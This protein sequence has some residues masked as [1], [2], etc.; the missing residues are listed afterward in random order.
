MNTF[1]ITKLPYMGEHKE[2][3]SRIIN[4]TTKSIPFSELH[5][6]ERAQVDERLNQNTD[7]YEVLTAKVEHLSQLLGCSEADAE[8]VLFKRIGTK[9]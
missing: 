4:K 3:T 8:R 9:A 7:P 6:Y 2:T 1:V 5:D